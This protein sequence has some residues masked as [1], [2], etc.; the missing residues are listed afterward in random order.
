MRTVAAFAVP[1]RRRGAAWVLADFVC[2]LWTAACGVAVPAAVRQ[3]E[4]PFQMHTSCAL[5]AVEFAAPARTW[6]WQ[7]ALGVPWTCISRV[8]R[9]PGRDLSRLSNGSLQSVHFCLRFCSGRTTLLR[10][11]FIVLLTRAGCARRRPPQEAAAARRWLQCSRSSLRF[12]CHIQRRRLAAR[13]AAVAIDALT[14]LTGAMLPTCAALQ[15]MQVSPI[16]AFPQRHQRLGRL[17]SYD[18]LL[19]WLLSAAMLFWQQCAGVPGLPGQLV[20]L[21]QFQCDADCMSNWNDISCKVR[22]SE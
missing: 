13:A 9:G 10:N 2:L 14:D 6:V 1:S 19:S 12:A 16:A 17:R 8:V 5:L 18:F 3:K 7:A 21:R 22:C 4:Q 20:L 15:L 11:R